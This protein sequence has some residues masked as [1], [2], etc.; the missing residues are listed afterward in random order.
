MQS[1]QVEKWKLWKE[2]FECLPRTAFIA[3]L[4]FLK[5]YSLFQYYL[6][7]DIGASVVEFFLYT[8][9]TPN[10]TCLSKTFI[11]N[12]NT[13]RLSIGYDVFLSTNF[14]GSAHYNLNLI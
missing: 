7:Y 12:N 13:Q 4:L 10:D 3:V 9:Q 11:K 6:K 2:N 8:T 5:S 1:I 14:L